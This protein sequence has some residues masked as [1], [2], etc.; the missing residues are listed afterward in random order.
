MSNALISEMGLPSSE[1]ALQLLSAV[2]YFDLATGA[3]I[4]NLLEE[5]I[6]QV[7]RSA[8]ASG[9]LRDLTAAGAVERVRDLHRVTDVV[10]DRY[11]ALALTD[12]PIEA[13]SAIK[14]FVREA[15][16]AMKKSLTALMGI[17]ARLVTVQTLDVIANPE[18]PSKFDVLIETVNKSSS[19][20]RSNDSS[21]AA[22]LLERYNEPEDRR[23]LFMR[24]LAHWQIGQHTAA[25]PLFTEVLRENIHDKAQGVAAHLLGVFEHEQG[26]TD[27]ALALVRKAET[28]LKRIGDHRGLAITFTSHARIL[29][30]KS[31]NDDDLALLESALGKYK[32]ARKENAFA[33]PADIRDHDYSSGRI[34][35]GEGQTRYELGETEIAIGFVERAVATFPPQSDARLWAQVILAGMYRD[36]NRVEDAIAL[37]S[38][39]V[40]QAVAGGRND[41][42]LARALNVLASAERRSEQ[43]DLASALRHATHSVELGV[44][45][46]SDRHV[47]H[48]LVTQALIETEM[49][50]PR[51]QGNSP[52]VRRIRSAL[53]R[54]DELLKK[55]GDRHGRSM[56]AEA[57]AALPKHAVSGLVNPTANHLA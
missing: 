50:E 45:H 39:E 44:E 6:D 2:P 4:V 48:A 17:R 7:D 53:Y 15:E 41:M 13:Q 5:R 34:D 27:K 21:S 52:E 46:R 38:R 37:L 29:R 28:S 47:A 51:H 23:L 12:R 42:D 43:P 25:A 49:L 16:H 11:L 20:G 8:W 19:L 26:R 40:A 57:I 55:V 22:A 35:V 10:R 33:A 31:R 24:G 36:E 14:V 56:V 3:D 54:A 32:L 18:F 30:D 1:M 9:V